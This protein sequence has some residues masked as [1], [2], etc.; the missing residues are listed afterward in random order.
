MS[1]T[2]QAIDEIKGMIIR[3]ELRPGDRLPKEADLA[4]R[5]GLSRNSLREAVRALT[6]IRILETRQGDGTYVT[7]LEPDILLET[8]SFVADFHQDRTL[9]HVLE[10]R[11]MLESS[12]AAL[13][14]QHATEEELEALATLVSEMD[15]CETVEAFV[16][17]DLA[18]HRTIAVA[19]RN[20]VLAS[21]LDSFSSRTSRAR[22]W[23]GVTQ[24]GAIE[25]T[26][27]DH[28]AIYAALL[29]RRV[30]IAAGLSIA[31]VSS[32][33]A[34]LEHALEAADDEAPESAAA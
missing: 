16:E 4:G 17:N 15:A 30:D 24:A 26:K 6:L 19:S 2:Q 23:R 1:V 7:S 8:I 29:H 32:V 3:G 18:F 22:V 27:A 20:P 31:H 13:A 21:L 9:L 11:R 33:E 12:A 14:A 10:V 34:W 28:Q 5:L 25:Q